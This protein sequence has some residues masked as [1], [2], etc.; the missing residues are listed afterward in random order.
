MG[1]FNAGFVSCHSSLPCSLLLHAKGKRGRGEG[2][3]S[4]GRGL[5]P[6]LRTCCVSQWIAFREIIPSYYI[7]Y[8]TETKQMVGWKWFKVTDKNSKS[9][10]RI[11]KSYLSESTCRCSIY[12]KANFISL[13]WSF[14][15]FCFGFFFFLNILILVSI[16]TVSSLDI[17]LVSDGTVLTTPLPC[18][19]LG[20]CIKHWESI[21]FYLP[22]WQVNIELLPLNFIFSPVVDQGIRDLSPRAF[23][24]DETEFCPRL[25]FFLY[26]FPPT[27][28][29]LLALYKPQSAY[30]LEQ[31]MK[32]QANYPTKQQQNWTGK[33]TK[34][35][36][37]ERVRSDRNTLCAP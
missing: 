6:A 22:C 11:I 23:F 32:C 3:C 8:V 21:F 29:M 37:S 19:C 10:K 15:G 16:W 2:Y 7:F 9:W 24:I 17:V 25:Q 14:V 33:K 5:A 18:S 27:Y 34:C 13:K 31:H 35:L 1:Q 26:L 4:C 28:H 12:V 30:A 20:T 36:L